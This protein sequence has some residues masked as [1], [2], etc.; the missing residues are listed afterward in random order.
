MRLRLDGIEVDAGTVGFRT[1]DSPGSVEVEGVDLRV[2]GVPVFA[3]GAV[4][5]PVDFAGFAAG[6]ADVRAAVESARDA[7][8]NLLRVPGTG[9]YEDDAFHDAC[10]EL[11]VLVWQ[12]FMFANLDYPV[13]DDAFRRLVEAEVRDVLGRRGGSPSLAVLCGNSEVEQ[14]AA[15]LGL[16]PL[17]GRG[18]LF[19][20]LLPRLVREAEVDAVYVPSAPTGGDLPFR[21]DRGVANYY[22]VGA[23]LR[24]LEDARRAGVRFAAE[25]LAFANVPNEDAVAEVLPGGAASLAVDDRRWKAGVPRDS[26]ATWDFED[27][28]DHYFGLLFGLD[29][30]AVRS[31]DPAR[32]LELSRAVSGEV[33]AETL[34]EWRRPGSPTR[35][36]LVLWLRDL[37]PGAGW[38][39]TDHSGEPKVAWHHVRRA[40][41]PVAVWTTDEGLNGID[42]HVANDRGVA[43][44]GRLRIAL[45]AGRE[46]LVE[47]V[48]AAVDLP[49]HAASTHNVEALLGRFS[50][51][52]YAYRFGPPGHD[53]LV[54]SL[55]Q[56]DGLVSQAVRFPAGRPLEVEAARGLGLEAG[57]EPAAGGA[58]LVVRTRRLAYGVR[59]HGI[60]LAA[61]DDAFCVEPGRERRVE[62][63]PKPGRALPGDAFLTALNLDGRV[64]VPL[65]ESGA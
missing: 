15:M 30:V 47:E 23:Y 6:A 41:A 8:M 14:Q 19:G 17:L 33:M 45:Y 63:R 49:A 57:A 1:L 50:D 37:L 36:A 59:V 55:E 58:A 35:G 18:E 5:T 44:R 54:A 27:V 25:C 60:D 24:P 10:D 53:A 46:Q 21:T 9:V 34:G 39:L 42:V 2:N 52:S 28:R 38:G 31:A 3:R 11:G 62:L 12:D 4:W 29:P 32:Y 48:A 64:R 26:G 7:G 51:V 43:F 22:G 16:D 65:P 61:S 56:E 40:F 20:E 13:A